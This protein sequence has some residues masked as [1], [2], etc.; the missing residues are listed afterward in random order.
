MEAS[1]R[2]RKARLAIFA[3]TL[4][5]LLLAVVLIAVFVFLDRDTWTTSRRLSEA[6]Q[7]A[8]SVTLV[9]YAKNIDIIR[10]PATPDEI[11][12]L[13]NITRKWWRPFLPTSGYLCF[14]AHHRIEIVNADGS[15]SSSAISFLCEQ[16]IIENESTPVPLPRYLKE[17]LTAFFT[18]ARMAPKT[19]DEYR[20]IGEGEKGGTAK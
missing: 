4:V 16:F 6:L 17:P 2:D 3:G 18:S 13:R 15:Q 20:A 9:E 8:R 12:R 10:R 11:R 14:E 19:Y 1:L 7:S 5:L